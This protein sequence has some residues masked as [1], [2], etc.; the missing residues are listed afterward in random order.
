MKTLHPEPINRF[1][2]RKRSSAKLKSTS[3]VVEKVLRVLGSGV[4]VIV[5][6]PVRGGAQQD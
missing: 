4:A 2:F 3:A 1:A 5:N 6:V